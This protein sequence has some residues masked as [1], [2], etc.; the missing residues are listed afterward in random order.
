MTRNH[1][2]MALALSLAFVGT[3]LAESASFPLT[4]ENSKVIFVG[5]KKTGTH[6]GDFKKLTGTATLKDAADPTTLAL[7]VVID[8][9]SMETDD[10]KLT[11]HLKSPD[12]FEVK[13]YPEAKFVSTEI[14]KSKDGYT[15]TGNLTMHGVTKKLSF[16]ADIS[17]SSDGL[18]LNSKFKLNRSEWGISYG[19]GMVDEEVAMTIEVAAKK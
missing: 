3:L 2:L 18:K 12:F 13:R 7:N 19:K 5:A 4:G 8:V 9:N 15:V 16:P 6:T 17:A 1:T 11:G 14:A 10:P